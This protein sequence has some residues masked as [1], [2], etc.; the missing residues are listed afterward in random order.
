MEEWDGRIAN[1]E[2][3]QFWRHFA[4]KRLRKGRTVMGMVGLNIFKMGE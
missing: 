4:P 3:R 2:Y 1:I